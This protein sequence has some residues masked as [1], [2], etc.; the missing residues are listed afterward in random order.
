MQQQAAAAAA[1]AAAAGFSND[2]TLSDQ[3]LEQSETGNLL[4]D[5]NES[6]AVQPCLSNKPH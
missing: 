4:P 5:P 6:A 3:K 1:A 2:Y